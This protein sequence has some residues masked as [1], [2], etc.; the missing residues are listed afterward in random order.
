MSDNLSRYRFEYEILTANGAFKGEFVWYTVT[1]K[2][3]NIVE[4]A[5]EQFLGRKRI[6]FRCLRYNTVHML[7]VSSSDI[8][9][10]TFNVFEFGQD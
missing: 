9:A 2:V 8:I 10:G 5:N 7:D 3:S 1:T 6:T 4:F